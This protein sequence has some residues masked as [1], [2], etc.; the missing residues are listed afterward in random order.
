M[1]SIRPRKGSGLLFFDFRYQGV[2]CREQTTLTDTAIN[3]KRMQ[4]VLDRIE[5][6]ISLGKFEY[7]H[8]FPGSK[9][10]ERFLP[11]AKDANQPAQIAAPISGPVFAGFVAQ[12][13]AQK[14]VEWRRSYQKTMDSIIGSHL[15]PQFGGL[16][17]QQVDRNAVLGFRTDLAAIE[18][19]A[20]QSK[21]KLSTRTI[22]HIIGVLR[23]IMDEAT[24]QHGVPN[25]CLSIKRL[26]TKRPEIEPFT[27]EETQA[28]IASVRTDYKNYLTVR[29]YTGL[30]SGEVNGLK[31]KHIDFE[32]R[33]ILIRETFVM[34][35]IEYTKND[36][37]QRE[38][39]MSEPVMRALKEQ[40]VATGELSEYVFCARS[41]RPVDNKNFDNRV[42]KPLLRNLGYKHRRPYQMR[43]TA[44]TLWLGAGENPEWIAR[45][46]GH[47]TT[48]MLFRVYSRYVP[49]LTR[50]D[51][52]AF[53]RLFS[54]Q[55]SNH[56]P[57]PIN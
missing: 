25:P 54:T 36:G 24:L 37:S 56:E 19:G 28:L 4:Q 46:L 42:W 49:N 17:L 11:T 51:G 43:H 45:Q 33:Q 2:R 47:S 18:C 12:W 26:K 44:A 9:G 6:D 1:S 16:S 48:E 57:A 22:N 10:G 31:W 13:K 20:G 23:M 7:Q 27:L 15:L 21:R 39:F 5:A 35:H 38:I 14:S 55:R 29:F 40:Q 41:G 3:R 53:E 32:R 30:R 8:Y 50:K 34:G 52:S